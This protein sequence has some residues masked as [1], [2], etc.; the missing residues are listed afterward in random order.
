MGRLQGQV[1]VV[2]GGSRGIG[3][4][5]ATRFAKEGARVVVC[6]RKEE[7]VLAA[8]ER[9]NAISALLVCTPGDAVACAHR[10]PAVLETPQSVLA[11]R[12]AALKELLPR[13][14]AA[15]I[16]RAEPRLLLAGDGDIIMG[17]VRRSVEAIKRDLPGINADKLLELEPRMMFEDIS[18]GLEALRELWPEEAFRQSDADNPFFAEELALAIKALNGKGSEKEGDRR[19]SDKS[20]K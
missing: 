19:R 9:I 10:F 16:F 5:I 18:S 2:T 1:A 20:Y 15:L 11:A 8:A 13:A 14:D 3:E 6:S 4:A 12:M 17:N 7:G